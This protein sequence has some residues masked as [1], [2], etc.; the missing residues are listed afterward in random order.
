VNICSV[1]GQD[2]GTEIA[3]RIWKE[4]KE[5]PAL[6]EPDKQ[7]MVEESTYSFTPDI[8][9]I[10]DSMSKYWMHLAKSC[11]EIFCKGL[12]EVSQYDNQIESFAKTFV[13]K[14]GSGDI[15][16]DM[17]WAIAC[18][19]LAALSTIIIYSP[20]KD[21]LSEEFK[22]FAL[23]YNKAIIDH[24]LASDTFY[25]RIVWFTLW[26]GNKPFTH[27]NKVAFSLED[28]LLKELEIH[29]AEYIEKK[30][31]TEKD[32]EYWH[33]IRYF[34]VIVYI[35]NWE[36]TLKLYK[37]SSSNLD[38]ENYYKITQHF[39]RHNTLLIVP[40]PI[41]NAETLK[42][43]IDLPK[44]TNRLPPIELPIRPLPEYRFNWESSKLKTLPRVSKV[45]FND[46]L[47]IDFLNKVSTK[48]LKKIKDKK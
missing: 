26:A 40:R 44:L 43:E 7:F 34:L 42:F 46:L 47:I 29:Y 3:N 30:I 16:S 2:K 12:V 13:S 21:L 27:K 48:Q 8:Y 32:H 22:K 5:V 4:I 38:G 10:D 9:A 17:R 14:F 41:Y 1:Y 6:E 24:S 37:V 39:V 20:E 19:Q 31:W 15:M 35:C 45:F 28:D 18:P 23:H 25:K 11:Q 36:D 33:A